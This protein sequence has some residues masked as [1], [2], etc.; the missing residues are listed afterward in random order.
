ML[1][2]L[3]LLSF[4]QIVAPVQ[5]NAAPLVAPALPLP[6]HSSRYPQGVAV[7]QHQAEVIRPQDVRA[8]PGQLDSVPVFNSN[9]P[10]VV[11]SEGILLSTFPPEGMRQSS[12]HLNFP[13]EGRFDLFAHHIARGIN[14]DDR[15]TL[16]MGVV[17]YN[18]GTAPVTLKILQGV[19]YLSQDAPFTDLPAYVANPAGA[20]FAGPGSRITT[21]VLREQRQSQWPEEITIPP[22][23]AKLLMNVPIPLR[24]LTVPTDGT[25]PPGY[26]IPRPTTA[27]TPRAVRVASTS[28]MTLGNRTNQPSLPAEP[29]FDNRPLAVNGR[30]ALMRLSSSDKVYVASLSMYAPRDGTGN[31]RVPNLS[32]WLN[33]LV[34]GGLAGPRDR[35]PTAP[36]ARAYLRFFYGR[37]SGVSQ[38]SQ[39]TALATDSAEVDHVTIPKPGQE[40]SYVISTVEHNTFG[41]EQIQSAPMLV[42]YPDTAYR[43][44]GNYGVLYNISL[45]LYNNTDT[46]QTV[47]VMLQT[48]LQDEQLEDGLR[49][50]LPRLIKSFLEE[51]FVSAILMTLGFLKPVMCMWC[52]SGGKKGNLW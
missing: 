25:L 20:V 51:R 12:A 7:P 45:P 9:S 14:P 48:P 17:V 27:V 46:T 6:A 30:S 21:E 38:G 47:N 19:S 18:P 24:Q 52:S 2:V 39:W 28:A 35:R 36:D 3:S 26:L 50:R 8:L 1:T 43:A 40:F 41:T 49:F 34:S 29:A 22:K 10:E 32:E 42:R 37:V 13:F 11:Q 23:Q 4:A 16:F 15:R 44:N 31:E 5:A 33:L